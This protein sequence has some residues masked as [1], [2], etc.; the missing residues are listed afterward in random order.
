VLRIRDVLSRIPDPDPDIFSFRIPD[1]DIFHHGSY[2][3][4]RMKSKNY[5]FYAC[6]WFQEEDFK[7]KKI[8]HPMIQGV[9]KH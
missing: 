8:T 4:G 2:I 6:L 7:I 3:K 9:K 5:L 1:P